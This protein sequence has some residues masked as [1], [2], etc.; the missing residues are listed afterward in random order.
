[1][2]TQTVSQ[3][4]N[5]GTQCSASTVLLDDTETIIDGGKIITGSIDANSINANTISGSSLTISSFSDASNYA[6][7]EDLAD[8]SFGAEITKSMSGERTIVTEDA[9]DLPLLTIEAQG[10][11][12]QDGT[13]TPDAPVEIRSVRGRNLVKLTGRTARPTTGSNPTDAKVMDG[14]GYWVSISANGYVRPVVTE[15]QIQDE[16]VQFT[17][18]QIAYGVGFEFKLKTGGT[19][20]VTYKAATSGDAIRVGFFDGDGKNISYS[21]DLASGA[22]FTVPSNCDCC[23]VVLKPNTLNQVA[24]YSEIQLELGSTPTPYVPYGYVGLE[25]RRRNLAKTYVFSGSD[26]GISFTY[27]GKG[28][29]VSGS[30]GNSSKWTKPYRSAATSDMLFTLPAGTYTLNKFGSTS[31]YLRVQFVRKSDGTE[32]YDTFSLDN[33]TEGFVRL[34]FMPPQQEQSINEYVTFQ[35]ERGTEATAYEPYRSVSYIDLKGEELCSL[36]DGTEDV[37]TVDASGHVEIEKRTKKFGWDDIVN[38]SSNSTRVNVSTNANADVVV[39]AASEMPV[40]LATHLVPHTWSGTTVPGTSFLN[41]NN[42][43]I[44][45]N[46][47]PGVAS[48]LVELKALYPD[49]YSIHP[50]K[51]SQTIDLGYID[52]PQVMDGSTVYV[53][54]EVQP[55]ISGSW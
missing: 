23:V 8:V 2:Q 38:F 55:I 1:M 4:A 16:T 44:G 24:T 31:Q 52:M 54:A 25:V 46:F 14:T 10:E 18:A 32:F 27:D 13:P 11:S 42:G 33:E 51:E 17:T 40:L 15:V 41:P 26:G 6:T 9:A 28:C 45:W 21:G 36:P 34:A 7:Q 19:Y 39:P 37:L 49:A 12:V 48:T 5:N 53:A 20:C 47:S 35:L 22:S 29:M 3:A 43:A 50:L 30:A